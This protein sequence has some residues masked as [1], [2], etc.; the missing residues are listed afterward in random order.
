MQYRRD[1]SA[2]TTVV[3]LYRTGTS[4]SRRKTIGDSAE[5]EEGPYPFDIQNK[6]K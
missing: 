4:A 3:K 6:I 1:F 5:L 2:A